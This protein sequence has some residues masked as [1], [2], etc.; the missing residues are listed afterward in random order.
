MGYPSS[1]VKL[2]WLLTF[3]PALSICDPL[4]ALTV[5]FAILSHTH[6]LKYIRIHLQVYFTRQR[7]FEKRNSVRLS[8]LFLATPAFTPAIFRL[9]PSP[10]SR[11]CYSGPFFVYFLAFKCFTV[12]FLSLSVRSFH[13]LAPASRFPLPPPYTPGFSAL[14]PPTIL[15]P[16]PN[17][18]LTLQS[19]LQ[20]PTKRLSVVCASSAGFNCVCITTHWRNNSKGNGNAKWRWQWEI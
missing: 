10:P 1:A 14:S 19:S 8:F 2:H 18:P 4:N 6:T 17:P 12:S 3:P 16:S 5:K 13:L 11:L 15:P 9:S 7:K 20:P